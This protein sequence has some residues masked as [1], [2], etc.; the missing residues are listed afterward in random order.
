MG[1]GL[2]SC[3]CNTL[4]VE[5][6][7]V[8]NSCL[9][10]PEKHFAPPL[11]CFPLEGVVHGV[12]VC[13]IDS[14]HIVVVKINHSWLLGGS[15]VRA[16][17][18]H[19]DHCCRR[20]TAQHEDRL[21]PLLCLPCQCQQ[22]GCTVRHHLSTLEATEQAKVIRKIYPVLV[23][24]TSERSV[25][26][27]ERLGQWDTGVVPVGEH[28]P[29]TVQVWVDEVHHYLGQLWEMCELTPSSLK[30]LGV[31]QD[32]Q[33]ISVGAIRHGEGFHSPLDWLLGHVLLG[34]E[35]TSKANHGLVNGDVT[36]WT[37]AR[38]KLGDQMLQHKPHLV[39]LSDWLIR[40]TV[41]DVEHPEDLLKTVAGEYLPKK[42]DLTD[43]GGL[44]IILKFGQ[45]DEAHVED[46]GE[47]A[48]Q[49]R[50]GDWF[51]LRKSRLLRQLAFILKLAN[52]LCCI[53]VQY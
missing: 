26:L 38:L 31:E 33:K 10:Q 44:P 46:D 39:D 14:V 5:Y 9:H 32:I 6:I 36:A 7:A 49:V 40:L 12:L 2:V 4:L 29:S 18:L 27:T 25:V 11:P 8:H 50:D 15:I 24:C 3:C 45:V 47:E 22:L 23:R 52:S 1:T 37:V 34:S 19:C 21:V 30:C 53:P 35:T 48:V 16:L 13:N 20:L 28:V 42:G 51:P 43:P 41:A 17:G